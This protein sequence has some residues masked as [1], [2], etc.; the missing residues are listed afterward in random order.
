MGDILVRILQ[1]D[2]R[3]TLEEGNMQWI[4]SRYM[5][6]SGECCIKIPCILKDQHFTFLYNSLLE[7]LNSA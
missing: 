7:N 4:I 6:F 5:S 1:N 2:M 3:L